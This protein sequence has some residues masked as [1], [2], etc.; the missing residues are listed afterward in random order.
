M[1]ICKPAL[2]KY[3]KTDDSDWMHQQHSTETEAGKKVTIRVKDFEQR[4]GVSLTVDDQ[5]VKPE[6][7]LI[8]GNF[9]S[10]NFRQ[11]LN[12]R[13]SNTR[14]EHA[15]TTESTHDAGLS[16]IFFL[17]GQ[18]D[19]KIG[20]QNFG[21]NPG[22]TG[23]I[24][25]AG[26]LKKQAESFQRRTRQAQD[27]RHLVITASPQWLDDSGFDE[28]IGNRLNWQFSKFNMA[29]QQWAPTGQ[30]QSLIHNIF[31]PTIMAPELL[32]LYLES[33]S[34]DIV[35][36]TLSIMLHRKALAE[37]RSLLNRHDQIR[38]HRARE[39]IL[40][41][42]GQALSIENIAHEVGISHSGLQRLFKRTEGCSVF[43]YV[44][45]ARLDRARVLLRQGGMN[46]QEVSVVAGYN[47]AANFA[48]A[49]KR[50]FGLSPRDI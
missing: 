1:P 31:T 10:K 49:F 27:V 14:E 22:N 7:T 41:D 11:G 25:A 28:Y 47:S 19:V 20:Q 23:V 43:E 9:F 2:L 21:F 18:V 35:S 17:Q 24:K 44:R 34:I 6:D 33:R 3:S 46:V 12:L 8:S 16:C 4:E 36:E 37:P 45:A 42:P 39:L 38:I 13:C 29:F 15:F 32:N 26:L 50:K 30:L 48:T 40:S 5:N